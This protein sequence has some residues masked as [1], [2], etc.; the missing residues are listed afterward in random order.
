MRRAGA[1][2][3][4]SDTCPPAASLKVFG[5]ASEQLESG[6]NVHDEFD[7][8]FLLR[9]NNN[10]KRSSHTVANGNQPRHVRERTRIILHTGHTPR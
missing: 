1:S 4:R 6:V 9:K 8:L 5:V 10:K 7:I 2:A 3:H